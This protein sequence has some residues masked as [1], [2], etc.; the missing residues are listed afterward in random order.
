MKYNSEDGKIRDKKSKN[1]DLNIANKIKS[2]INWES[3]IVQFVSEVNHN[4]IEF[5]MVCEGEGVYLCKEE[6][7]DNIKKLRPMSSIELDNILYTL[8]GLMSIGISL[9]NDGNLD[10]KS[11]KKLSEITRK[12]KGENSKRK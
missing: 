12:I 7:H 1:E 8:F 10:K 9:D 6:I 2:P 5:I 4:T 11:K 3:E